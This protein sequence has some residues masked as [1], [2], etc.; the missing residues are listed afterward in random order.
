MDL[1][2][3]RLIFDCVRHLNFG[4]VF[5]QFLVKIAYYFFWFRY[6]VRF[7]VNPEILSDFA[8]WD[9]NIWFT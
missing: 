7:N 1:G 6:R 2:F 4:L 9:L 5:V 3:Y 8:E